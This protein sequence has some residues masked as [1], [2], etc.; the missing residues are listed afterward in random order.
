[1]RIDVHI[2]FTAPAISK[3]GA[4][5]REAVRICAGYEDGVKIVQGE[6][7][8]L[9][10]NHLSAVSVEQRLRTWMDSALTFRSHADLS[11]RLF[12]DQEKE[13]HLARMSNDFFAELCQQYPTR[14]TAF[15]SVPRASG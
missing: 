1:L 14:F 3:A 6:R 2:I 9:S 15:G 5:G 13:S 4:M 12:F 11:E 10:G 8:A 7:G